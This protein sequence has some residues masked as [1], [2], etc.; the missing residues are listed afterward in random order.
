MEATAR[1]KDVR[2][3]ERR[4]PGCG[5]QSLFK[6]AENAPGFFLG[7]PSSPAFLP[8]ESVARPGHTGTA[9]ASAPL[10][11]STGERPRAP[12]SKKDKPFRRVE[13]KSGAAVLPEPPTK[14]EF[15]SRCRTPGSPH[16]WVPATNLLAVSGRT[17]WASPPP[18]T[19]YQ[20]R[21]STQARTSPSRGFA[22]SPTT[23]VQPRKSKSSGNAS[24]KVYSPRRRMV[25][26]RGNP[27]AAPIYPCGV[28]RRAVE[29]YYEGIRCE[30]GCN[31]WFHRSCT[32]F[33]EKAFHSLTHDAYTKWAGRT[34]RLV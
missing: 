5:R 26:D 24:G 3:P 30:V 27:A 25:Y 33:A 1:V 7:L 10:T 14:P 11:V 17:H 2:R 16:K 9:L 4:A 22:E 6:R 32:G 23:A 12:K 8:C 18:V 13:T 20:S 21:I 28:C 31:F 15:A 29:D 19:L 34:L